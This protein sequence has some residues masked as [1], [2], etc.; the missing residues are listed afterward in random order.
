MTAP[1]SGLAVAAAVV[2]LLAGCG[3]G[4]AERPAS[5]TEWEGPVS[6]GLTVLAASSLT[7]AFETIGASFEAVHPGTQLTFSFG[8]SATLAAQVLHGAPADVLASA[9]EDTM[10]RVTAAGVGSTP[11]VF[12]TNT[13]QIA[14]PKGNPAGIRGLADFGDVSKRIAVCAAQVPCGAAAEKVFGLAG[15]TARP[16]TVESNVK[17]ALQ[18]AELGEVDATLVYRTDVRAASDRVDGIEFAE[19]ASA[20]NRYPI[21]ALSTGSNDSA[22]ATFVDYVCSAEGRAVLGESGFGPP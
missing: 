19:S 8:S 3:L 14:V 12:A 13:L 7:E 4:P 6:G 5:P 17:A 10:G 21:A 2:L 11:R 20:V 18:K 15:V 9:D 22:A 16:D 1:G